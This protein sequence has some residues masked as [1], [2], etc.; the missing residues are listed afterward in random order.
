MAPGDLAASAPSGWSQRTA[1]GHVPSAPTAPTRRVPAARGRGDRLRAEILAV[2]ARL[3]DERGDAAAV[4]IRAVADAIGVTPPSIYLHFADKDALI[5]AVCDEAFRP[6]ATELQA[7][8]DAAPDPLAALRA[9]GRVYVGFGL[10]RPQHYRVLFLSRNARRVDVAAPVGERRADA[11]ALGHLVG[12]VR[13]CIDSGQFAPADPMLVALQL[14]AGL[15]GVV[16][17]LLC[18]HGVPWPP[19]AV[20][21]DSLLDTQCRGLASRAAVAAPPYPP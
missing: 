13:R 5:L 10:A 2:T 6:L 9:S 15:H 11:A 16:S 1:P 21:V 19:V 12:S 20:L 8:A 7:A 4:S 18:E 17:L 3:L 14:W